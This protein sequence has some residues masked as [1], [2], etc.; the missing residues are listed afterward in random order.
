VPGVA[1][2]GAHSWA[3]ARNTVMGNIVDP[4]NNFAFEVHQYFDPDSS[5]T[6]S[7]AVG[8]SIGSE[9]IEAFQQWCRGLHFKAFLGEFA[10]GEDPTSLAALNDLCR[11][12]ET[13]ADVWLGW[14]AWA[15]GEW[16]PEN[17]IFSLEPAKDGR[18]RPQTRVLASFAQHTTAK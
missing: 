12:L 1:Y 9:R 5:G 7:T 14:A 4:A 13:N 2:T 11:T 3:L 6:S 18:M 17:Y 16:W 8:T 10:A 15:G